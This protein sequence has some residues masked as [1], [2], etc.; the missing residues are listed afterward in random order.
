MGAE[1][2]EGAGTGEEGESYGEP[3]EVVLM[4]R[5]LFKI[6]GA[7]VV[8]TQDFDGAIRYRFIKKTPFGIRCNSMLRDCSVILN[9]D[10]SCSGKSYVHYW[11]EI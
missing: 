11:K 4:W 2:A 3:A 7:R 10:G 5:K 9:E 8:A 1:A 6:F